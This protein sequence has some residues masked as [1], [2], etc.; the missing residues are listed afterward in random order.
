MRKRL[1]LRANTVAIL[2]SRQLEIV[3]G[4]RRAASD[5]PECKSENPCPG[6]YTWF[7]KP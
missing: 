5:T 3:Q 1:K 4:G 6:E 7:C 2:T